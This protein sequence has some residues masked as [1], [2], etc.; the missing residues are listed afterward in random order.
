MDEIKAKFYFLLED[1]LDEVIRFLE[2]QQLIK[3]D[4]NKRRAKINS[5][6]LRF[7]ELPPIKNFKYGSL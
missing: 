2:E 4:R 5:L 6:G 7:L 3:L 1:K